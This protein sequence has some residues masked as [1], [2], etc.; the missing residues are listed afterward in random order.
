MYKPTYIYIYICMYIYICKYIY[1]H[2][3]HIHVYTQI[4]NTK[5]IVNLFIV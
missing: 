3:I 1:I 5:D 2:Y 4:Y